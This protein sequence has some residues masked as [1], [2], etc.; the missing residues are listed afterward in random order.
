MKEL[1]LFRIPGYGTHIFVY[2]DGPAQRDLSWPSFP[3]GGRTSLR[4]KTKVV[5]GEWSE[6]KTF[7]H[8]GIK[9]S[10]PTLFEIAPR[11]Y[12]A[13]W[14]SGRCTRSR[15]QILFGKLKLEK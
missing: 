5:G 1:L 4:Y 6:Q 8:A 2:S 7:F 10:Y 13:V 3:N 9:N 14:D 12:R 11:D 15:T